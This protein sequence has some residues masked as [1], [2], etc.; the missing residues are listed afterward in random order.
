MRTQAGVIQI[1][2]EVVNMA[3]KVIEESATNE[4]IYIEGWLGALCRLQRWMG[5]SV[6]GLLEVDDD[7]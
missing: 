4:G 2:W 5:L 7:A 3:R 6:T 1:T